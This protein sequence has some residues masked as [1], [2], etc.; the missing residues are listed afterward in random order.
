MEFSTSS[1]FFFVSLLLIRFAKCASCAVL[2]RCPS[3]NPDP[4][5]GLRLLRS[6]NNG[7]NNKNSISLASNW[8]RLYA[9]GRHLSSEYVCKPRYKTLAWVFARIRV[10]VCVLYELFLGAF[11]MNPSV[12]HG[13]CGVIYKNIKI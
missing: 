2:L 9:A 11:N 7:N 5:A 1:S 8:A 13:I 6:G 4:I 10:C 12:R 3:S